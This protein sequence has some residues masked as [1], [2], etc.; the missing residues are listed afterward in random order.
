MHYIG[1]LNIIELK[2]KM[3]NCANIHCSKKYSYKDDK[4]ERNKIDRTKSISISL[5]QTIENLRHF[6]K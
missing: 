1:F 3:L 4:K 2:T 6:K 5:L